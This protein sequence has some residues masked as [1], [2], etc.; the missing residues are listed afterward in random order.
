MAYGPAEADHPNGTTAWAVVVAGGSGAR[1]GGYKQF[2]LLAGREVVEWSLEAAARA[3]AGVV[4]VVPA[5]WVEKYSGRADHVVAGGPTRAASV[6]AGLE[7]IPNDAQV[8][9]VHDA[10]R[11]LASQ[12][13]WASVIAAIEEG[14]DGAVPCVPVLDTIKQ[15]QEDGKL[16]TLDRAR[17][18]AVQTPQAFSAAS[19]RAA[20]AGQGEATDDAALVEAM[21]G[22]VVSVAGEP[23]NIKVTAPPDLA[24]AEMLLSLNPAPD[25]PDGPGA[26]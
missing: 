14:A 7:V 21:G 19:L 3:C 25:A 2:M 11:P 9:V 26:P 13:T 15:R 17:L 24:L 23:S 22:R 5:D 1:F 6:R 12:R 10:V 4:L 18:L 8:V 16:M 20:H